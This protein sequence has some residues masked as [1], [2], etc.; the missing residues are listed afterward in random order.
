[1]LIVA[2]TVGVIGTEETVRKMEF[3]KCLR[4]WKDKAMHGQF[5]RDMPETTD[6]EQTWSWLISSDLKVQMEAFICAAQEQALGTNDVKHHSDWTA[7][8]P[9]CRMCSERECFSS[10]K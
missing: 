4:K 7:E 5:L 9:I 8:S 3:R 1:M 2:K 10:S 6:A